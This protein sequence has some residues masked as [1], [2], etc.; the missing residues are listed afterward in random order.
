MEVLFTLAIPAVVKA[1]QLFNEKDWASLAKIVLS[2]LV[3]VVGGLVGVFADPLTGLGIG[4]TASGIVTVA[5]YAGSKAKQTNV[6]QI[7][8]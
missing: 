2:A 7:N 8:Q 4:L 3:G 6:T 5:G 1:A